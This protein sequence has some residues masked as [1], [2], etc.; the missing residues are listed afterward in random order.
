MAK[1]VPGFFVKRQ[2]PWRRAAANLW[3]P[4]DDPTVFGGI[5]LDASPLLA[6]LRARE[7]LG[8]PRVTLTHVVVKA[9][10]LA[11]RAH[12]E[13]NAYVRMGRIYQRR[14]VDVFVL[15]A[16]RP[17]DGGAPS[18][19]LSGVKIENADRLSLAAIAQA[20]ETGARQARAG[21]EV[22]FGGAKRW[23]SRL[24][25]SLI[26]A[27]LRVVTYLQY[28][29]NLDLSP[30]GVPRDSFGGALVTNVGTF[31]IGHAYAPLA[32][33]ARFATSVVIGRVSDKPVAE[34]GQ[35][36][37]RPMLPLMTT[38]DHRVVDAYHA[39]RLAETLRA[40]LADPAAWLGEG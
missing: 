29:L 35:V 30:L 20:I 4:P 37:I 19:D 8:R 5:E 15:V 12:P 2:S 38:F 34:G 9:I 6:Y 24:P 13:C 22:V 14:D 23:A 18:A 7:A 32:P 31:G 40:G 25:P 1:N 39:S 16:V 27:G 11:L 36:V 17:E 26:S 3:S 10:A 33:V 21:D 28:E